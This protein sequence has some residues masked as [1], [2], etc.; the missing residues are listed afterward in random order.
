M[1]AFVKVLIMYQI[2][3]LEFTPLLMLLYPPS[4]QS[5][6]SFNRSHFSIS[7]HVYTVFAPYSPS[8]TFSP[9]PPFPSHCPGRMCSALL[10]SNFVKEKKMTFLF[11]I[12]TQGVSL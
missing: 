6:D 3:L 7:I 9:H 5:W 2:N 12:A 10:F 4:L 11:K 8:H 1:V